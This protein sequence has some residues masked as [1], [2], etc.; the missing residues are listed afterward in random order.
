M[1]NE[2]LIK[3]FISYLSVEKGL[4]ANT[5]EAYRRDLSQFMDYLQEEKAA[6]GGQGV[7]LLEITKTHIIDYI[8]HMR[9][10]EK[11]NSSVARV[12]S[13]LRSFSRFVVL[14]GLRKEDPTE[15]MRT[16]R[17]WKRLPD[18]L[19]AKE[20]QSLL[21]N[22]CTDR[23]ALR[24]R[25]ILELLYSSGLRASELTELNIGD[26]NF[27]AGFIMVTGKGSKQ[28]VV[29]VHE[30]ALDAIKTYMEELRSKLLKNRA[31]D[32]LFLA[33]G[34]KA[35]TRQRLWQIVKA[36][37]NRIAADASPHT[38][39]HCFASHL[40]EGG[41][42]LRAVQKMLGHADISTTQIYTHVTSDRLKTVHKK[43]HPR[44]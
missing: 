1:D 28:R 8:N 16:P 11:E 21:M 5:L 36:Y 2:A 15:N 40:L 18:T 41:A 44:G 10:L 39:R 22:A 14:E 42:D 19:P 20:V 35:M 38:L 27:N 24:D 43:H 23:F 31:T 30:T 26:I 29:P 7:C 9:T 4:S 12:M 33:S 13:S 17:G 6:G 32:K 34:G 37:A 25:A 3:R